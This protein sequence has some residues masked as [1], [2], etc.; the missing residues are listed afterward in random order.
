[1]CGSNKVAGQQTC[2][3]PVH[4]PQSQAS[5]FGEKKE[6]RWYIIDYSLPRQQ[7]QNTIQ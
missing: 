1:M 4:V 2:D 3:S 7:L 5:H 6:Q